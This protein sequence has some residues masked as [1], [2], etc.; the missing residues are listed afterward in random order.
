[1]VAG[2]ELK[3]FTFDKMVVTVKVEFITKKVINN[4]F[5]ELELEFSLEFSLIMDGYKY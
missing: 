2:V 3:D 5:I 4:G 1:M